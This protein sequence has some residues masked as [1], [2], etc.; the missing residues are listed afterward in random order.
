[1]GLLTAFNAGQPIRASDL[2]NLPVV[3]ATMSFASVSN[4]I[5]ETVVGTFT[6]PGGT[7]TAANQG[8][9]FQ[10]VGSCGGTG[11]PNLTARVRAGGLAGTLIAQSGPAAV[12][13]ASAWFTFDGFLYFTTVG[14]SGLIAGTINS[15]EAFGGGAPAP[16]SGQTFDTLNAVSWN[17]TVSTTLVVTAQFSVANAANT[18]AG[19][20][21]NAYLL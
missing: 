6:F 20:A 2:N 10:A 16:P 19:I 1:V 5:A 4:S 17:T 11:S 21:G 8:I 3:G 14:V 18:A 15:I 9:R 12:T 13:S 7:F